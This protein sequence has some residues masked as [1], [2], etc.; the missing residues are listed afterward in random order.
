MVDASWLWEWRW[1]FRYSPP[2]C[3][4]RRRSQVRGLIIVVPEN[5]PR[6]PPRSLEVHSTQAE[7]VNRHALPPRPW[8]RSGQ[9]GQRGLQPAPASASASASASAGGCRA[10][11]FLFVK[12]PEPKSVLALGYRRVP[13]NR[14]T[15]TRACA[16][17][18]THTRAHT[19]AH[20]RARA[21]DTQARAYALVQ[22]HTRT[23]ARTHAC[24]RH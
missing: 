23:H 17:T 5:A 14:D 16:H 13:P 18:R 2:I 19:H 24:T 6:A 7:V 4:L 12:Q 11:E 22:T 15:P 8:W 1:R 21:R 3:R 9:N 20:T 10:I